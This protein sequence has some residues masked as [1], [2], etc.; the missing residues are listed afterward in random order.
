MLNPAL[1]ARLELGRGTDA[2]EPYWLP[3][4]ED[5]ELLKGQRVPSGLGGCAGRSTACS[6]QQLDG[7]EK[8]LEG[9]TE[10]GD[11]A[12]EEVGKGVPGAGG[13]CSVPETAGGGREADRW[14]EGGAGSMGVAGRGRVA[15]GWAFW[16]PSAAGAGAE[17]Q[18]PCWEEGRC[19]DWARE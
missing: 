16:G 4:G 8:G 15:S 9:R 10:A 5:L 19:E 17:D 11:G 1:L 14:T 18:E 6:F 13:G 3:G 12:S 7:E 2:R